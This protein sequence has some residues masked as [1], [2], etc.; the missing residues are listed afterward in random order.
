MVLCYHDYINT[1]VKN[2]NEKLYYEKKVTCP[3]CNASFS[4]LKIRKSALRVVKTDDDFCNY[5]SHVNPI[6]YYVSICPYCYYAAPEI[7]FDKLSFREKQ[8]LKPALQSFKSS[9]DFEGKRSFEVA[10]VSLKL[11]IY[12]CEVRGTPKSILA[13]LCI[14]LAWLYRMNEDKEQERCFLS[15]AI[16]FYE[17]AFSAESFPIGGLSRAGV[18]YLIGE[19]YRRMGE[20]STALMWISR[21]VQDPSINHQPFINKKAREQWANIQEMIKQTS[22]LMSS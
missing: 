8:R 20:L 7:I 21:A 17:E 22:N 1:K 13:G 18:M 14:R 12:C 16:C 4:L 3:L 9:I 10:I 15:K 5:Y 6:Y 19:L 2:M 11:G